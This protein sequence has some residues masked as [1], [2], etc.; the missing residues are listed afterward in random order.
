MR[1]RATR[2]GPTAMRSAH[3][4]APRAPGHMPSTHR[5]WACSTPPSG[6]RPPQARRTAGSSAARQ[7][8]RQSAP[9]GH[10][11]SRQYGAMRGWATW[12]TRTQDEPAAPPRAASAPPRHGGRLEDRH[13][14]Q[15]AKKPSTLVP[16]RR[17]AQRGVSWAGL[18]RNAGVWRVVG[19]RFAVCM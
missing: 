16:A 13:G 7:P 4:F 19:G 3:F 17:R 15:R 18:V 10:E 9:S 11:G 12:R 1:P 6:P 14:T 5:N 2:H 8:R